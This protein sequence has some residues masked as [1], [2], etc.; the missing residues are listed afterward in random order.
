[1]SSDGE[2]EV[3]SLKPIELRREGVNEGGLNQ[4]LA[5]VS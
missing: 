2:K 3:R 1:M 5:E 4:S